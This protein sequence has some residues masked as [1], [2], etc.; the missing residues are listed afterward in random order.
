VIWSVLAVSF[1]YR[2]ELILCDISLFLMV[3]RDIIGVVVIWCW[4]YWLNVLMMSFIVMNY[5]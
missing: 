1:S 5:N 4:L 2:L 3:A